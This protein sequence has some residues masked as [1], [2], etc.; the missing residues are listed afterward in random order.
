MQN[1]PSTSFM[2]WFWQECTYSQET[3]FLQR[4]SSC[5]EAKSS[6]FFQKR[7]VPSQGELDQN[8]VRAKAWSLACK[9]LHAAKHS[10]FSSKLAICYFSWRSWQD[11]WTCSLAWE[12]LHTPNPLSLENLRLCKKTL[13]WDKVAPPPQENQKSATLAWVQQTVHVCTKPHVLE[14]HRHLGPNSRRNLYE[15]LKSKTCFSGQ[16]GGLQEKHPGEL[17]KITVTFSKIPGIT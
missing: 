7:S 15:G 8:D 2:E 5:I 11:N 14:E 1:I 17:L 13:A 9:K 3:L 4:A 12:K 16:P 10:L 6:V